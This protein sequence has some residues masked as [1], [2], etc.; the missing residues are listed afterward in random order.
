MAASVRALAALIAPTLLAPLTAAAEQSYAELAAEIAALYD[1]YQVIAMT[2]R[3]ASGDD[4]RLREALLSDPR[5]VREV[6]IVL[7]EFANAARQDVLDRHIFGEDVADEELVRVWRDTGFTAWESPGYRR[8][9]DRIRE[10]NRELRR[11]NPIRVLAGDTPIR[12]D[13]IETG[14]EL[15][16]YRD[17]GDYP[18]ASL[19]CEIIEPGRKALLVFGRTHI[20]KRFPM[21]FVNNLSIEE[22]ERVAVVD[23]IS[24]S[25]ELARRVAALAGVAPTRQLIYPIEGALADARLLELTM[26][27]PRHTLTAGE[28]VTAFVLHGTELLGTESAPASLATDPDFVAFRA[29]YSALRREQLSGPDDGDYVEYSD[30]DCA[31]EH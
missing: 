2:E 1:D 19:K 10:I 8:F 14:A 13:E 9:L 29:R 28:G 21:S 15:R 16:R 11:E 18:T 22:Q 3:H 25:P 6:E 31:S 24:Q 17:R 27:D 26:G 4:H 30:V 23:A 20:Y 5:F 7:V 12:W